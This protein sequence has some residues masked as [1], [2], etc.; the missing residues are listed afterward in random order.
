MEKLKELYEEYG[1]P[2]QSRLYK[3]AK[4]NKLKVTQKQVKE[5]LKKQS[6]QQQHTQIKKKK[7]GHIVA[8][9]PNNIFQA[10]LLDYTKYSRNNEGYKWILIAMDVFTRKAYARPLKNKK[11]S[12]VAN[13]FKEIIENNKPIEVMTDNGNEFLGKPFQVLIKDNNMIHTTNEVGDHNALGI[14]DRFS[15]TIKNSIAKYF[16]SR[17]TTKWA[18][19]L[20]KFIAAYNNTPNS[21]ILDFKPN[22]AKKHIPVITNLNL[23][24]F[25]ANKDLHDS[26]N[27]G[28]LVRTKIKKKRFSKGYTPNY[29]DEVFK[30][31]RETNKFVILE[32]GRR[33]NK[34]NVLKVDKPESKSSTTNVTEADRQARQNRIMQ[35]AGVSKSNIVEGK[36]TRK[37][38]RTP[39]A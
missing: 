15:R 19:I 30:V 7:K 38:K 23:E 13:A 34:A 37:P 21:A 16:T 4:D 9:S 17:N 14:I 6:V 2:G 1:Y 31:A 22:E 5:F 18:N 33:F 8:L 39:D 36:R 10:D 26:I 24:K 29:S 35:K 25:D 32:D 12:S 28:D 11:P 27:K 3:I 20:P